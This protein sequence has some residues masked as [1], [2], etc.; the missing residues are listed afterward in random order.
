VS[1][2]KKVGQLGAS[3]ST[4]VKKPLYRHTRWYS[5]TKKHFIQLASILNRNYAN[6]KTINEVADMCAD[7]NERFDRARF[8]K[9]AGM[10]SDIR[11]E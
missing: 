1:Q 8:Q 10:L 5:M 11:G 4:R 9:A 3:F 2:P 6:A 7:M